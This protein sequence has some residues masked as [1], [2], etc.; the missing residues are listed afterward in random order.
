M[1]HPQPKQAGRAVTFKAWRIPDDGQ[2]RTGGRSMSM[3]IEG[4]RYPGN[5]SERYG[6]R[7][8]GRRYNAPAFPLRIGD[9][10]SLKEALDAAVVAS[11]FHKDHIA[12]LEDD[13]GLNERT[14][15]FYQIKRDSNARYRGPFR[16]ERYY[17][18][19]P[20][21]LFS[22]AWQ[23]DAEPFARGHIPPNPTRDEVL[24]IDRQLVE[25]R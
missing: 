11:A 16:T 20:H 12:I 4:P 14:Y 19:Y 22:V 13:A 25:G 6:S 17:E 2:K 18:Y 24:G 8:T 1:T 15:H 10:A 9:P 3:P 7:C 21:H 5:V 23:G